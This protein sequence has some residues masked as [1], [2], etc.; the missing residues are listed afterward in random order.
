MTEQRNPGGTRAGILKAAMHVLAEKG[1]S[2]A[3]MQDV[4][5]ASGCT[6]PTIYYYFRSKEGLVLA[7]VEHVNS[8]LEN[9]IRPELE[10]DST[11]SASL[12]RITAELMR[13]HGENPDFA[14]AHLMCHADSTGIRSLFP[15]MKSRFVEVEDLVERL[16]SRG[17]ERGEFRPDVPIPVLC[18]TFSSI[19]HMALA[20]PQDGAG[21]TSSA[22][23]MVG[24]LMRG[25]GN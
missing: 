3:S 6:K 12:E 16:Y 7:L 22:G 21:Q 18:R 23:E 20:F 9:I 11:V 1:Y 5:D 15:S 8:M 25:I 10:A 4:A 24:I 17:V 14:K 19:L 13:M 2:E